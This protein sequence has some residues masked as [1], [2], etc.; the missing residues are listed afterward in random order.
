MVSAGRICCITAPFLLSVAVL[1]CVV[2]VFLAGIYDRNKTLNDLYF[3][4]VDLTNL[5]LTL[6]DVSSGNNSIL[7]GALQQAKETLGMNDYY[8]IYLRSYCHWNSN[9]DTYAN[10]T[11]PQAYFWFNPIKVWHLNDTGVPVDDFLPKEFRTGLDAYKAASKAIFYLYAGS[12]GAAAITI[13]VGIS[14]IFSRWGSFFTTFCA[15]AMWILLVAASVTVTVVYSL[16]RT[17]LNNTLKDD[18]GID[19]TLGTRVLGTTWLGAAF[20]LAAGFFWFFSVCCCSGRSPYNS[21]DKEARRTRAEKG[22]YTYERVGSPY[23]G[24][25]NQQSVPLTDFGPGNA[26]PAQR[27]TAYEPFRPQQV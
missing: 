15:T 9:Q 11:D 26:Y 19:S 16:V 27:G 7:E 23:L 10:C 13:L 1:I 12:L 24:P 20:A 3:L 4:K 22:P 5:T 17:A 14:A 6:G 2:L 8:T 18:Y 25:T 21:S